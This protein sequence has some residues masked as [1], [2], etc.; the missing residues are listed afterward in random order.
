MEGKTAT[1][2]E[3][4][5]KAGVSISTVSRAFNNYDDISK[6][7][8]EL[9]FRIA[10]ELS[11]KP[12]IAT[13]NQNSNNTFRLAILVEDYETT[14]AL[15]QLV[16]EMQMSFQNTAS[17]LGY[18]T[19]ILSTNTDM[20]KTEDMQKMFVEKQ[21]DGA[22]IMGL[23][24]TDEYYSQLSTIHYPCVTF[25]ININNP[26]VNCIGMD[27]IR[28]AFMAVEHLIK[29]GH[30]KIAFINGHNEAFVSYERLDGYCLALNRYDIPFDK[31]LVANGHFTDKG[32]GAAAES[33]ISQYKDV[34]GIV[35]ASD[36]MAVGAINALD[37]LGYSVPD[38]ISIV[39]YDDLYLAQCM[40]PGL[41]TIQQD[42]K[43]LG[44][45]AANNLIN[46]VNGQSVGR[47]LIE[48]TLIIRDSTKKVS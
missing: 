45:I 14:G 15:N 2:R 35:C 17:K 24:M 48:P 28:G 33:L 36:L 37:K 42:T 44:E 18:E 29:L 3:V 40:N 46:M 16:F 21:V 27:N 32:G 12:T 31:R 5:K 1:I 38:D 7:T 25:D 23:K 30:K 13:R 11:Y 41:T 47:I 19:L 6:Q 20:Q 4:A 10:E 9:I 22:F 43:K 8:R 26:M 39:G 34:T